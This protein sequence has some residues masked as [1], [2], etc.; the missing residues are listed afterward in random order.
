MS[1]PVDVQLSVVGKIVVNDERNLRNIQTSGPNVCGDQ[2]STAQE[3]QQKDYISNTSGTLICFLSTVFKVDVTSDRSS[4]SYCGTD[5]KYVTDKK[6]KAELGSVHQLLIGCG[7]Q[8]Y[9]DE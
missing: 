7:S 9:A 3:K 1:V 5:R 2:H 8:V 4:L 6:C